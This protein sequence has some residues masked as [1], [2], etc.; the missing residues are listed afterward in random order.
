[1]TSELDEVTTMPR[2]AVG[3][4]GLFVLLV[5]TTSCG[6]ADQR[7]ARLE[8]RVARLDAAAAHTAKS[9]PTAAPPM[10]ASVTEASNPRP[11]PASDRFE[12]WLISGTNAGN[13]RVVHDREVKQAGAAS[14]RVECL[15]PNKAGFGVVMQTIAADSYRG[16]RVRFSAAVR[17]RDAAGWVGLWMRV[18]RPNERSSSFD[19]MEDRPITGTTDWSRRTVVLDVAPDAADISFGLLLHG[20][21]TA[22]LDSVTVELVDASVP[23]TDL[24][25]GHSTMAGRPKAPVNLDLDL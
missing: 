18:D 15:V 23:V 5:S 1:M 11:L 4:L 25:I 20:A 2:Q 14:A 13:F 24:K 10:T 7:L 22:W 9:A 21:G 16:K 12:G 6:A 19:N 8:A 3:S 17:T